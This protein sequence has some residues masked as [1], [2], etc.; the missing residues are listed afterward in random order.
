MKKFAVFDID[1]TLIRWQLYHAVVNRL[2]SENLLGGDFY[3]QIHSA[4]LEWKNRAQPFSEYEDVL[5]RKFVSILPNV[6]AREYD[7][8]VRDIWNE[9][10]DQVYVY[11]RDLIKELREEGYFLL[12][13]SGSPSEIVEILAEYYGFDDFVACEFERNKSGH[14]TGKISTPVRDKK[15]ALQKLVDKHGLDWKNSIAVGDSG[16]DIAMLSQVE[17]PIAFNPDH[18]LFDTAREKGWE[19]VVER[20]N[21]VYKLHCKDGAYTLK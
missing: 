5:V 13:I 21:V 3:D 14:F 10:H 11:T 7:R 15:L 2:A 17:R 6:D 19:I 18:K 8:V 4:R 16:S 20:K 9:Y 1:G 12:I